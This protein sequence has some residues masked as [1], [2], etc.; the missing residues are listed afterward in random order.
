LGELDVDDGI[1]KLI[2]R[3]WGL[4]MDS[5]SSRHGAVVNMVLAFWDPYV[6]EFVEHLSDY[7]LSA[8]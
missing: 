7:H 2:L 1:S 5:I 3:K 4:S 8:S 6:R